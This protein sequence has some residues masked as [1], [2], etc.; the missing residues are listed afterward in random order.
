M[1][2]RILIPVIFITSSAIFATYELWQSSITRATTAALAA[3]AITHKAE[4]IKQS[5][6]HASKTKA[7]KAKHKKKL[8]QLKAK[9]RA[10]AKV[11]RAMT[12]V[13]I[14]GIAAMSLIEKNEYDE[15]LTENP[16]STFEDYSLKISNDINTLL[17]D[18]YTSWHSQLSSD[19]D[20]E[21]KPP[22]D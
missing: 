18:E 22:T 19:T 6:K 20:I 14:L 11:Q 2:L 16:D 15:W 7:I 3:Q 21:H 5:K 8:T 9:E 13:P 4:L 12:A 17:N 10:K 1:K